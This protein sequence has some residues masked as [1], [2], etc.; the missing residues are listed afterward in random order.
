MPAYGGK[1]P[2]NFR[3]LTT[4]LIF[5]NTINIIVAPILNIVAPMILIIL[6]PTI[7]NVVGR[8]GASLVL[9]EQCKMTLCHN[10][11]TATLL[12]NFELGHVLQ[13]IPFVLNFSAL[14]FTI[15]SRPLSLLKS[16]SQIKVI[17]S[18]KQLI[19]N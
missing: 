6:A 7:S 10:A 1:A 9:S 8:N 16:P 2:H 18:E 17:A 3:P 14:H 5:V 15:L 13:C 11:Q 4:T 12:I 19:N